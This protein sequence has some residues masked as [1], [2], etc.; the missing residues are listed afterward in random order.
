MNPRRCVI[1]IFLLL[2][3]AVDNRR[4]SGEVRL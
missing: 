1:D 2:K 3:D 4:R